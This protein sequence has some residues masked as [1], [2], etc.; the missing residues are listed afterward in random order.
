LGNLPGR[1]GLSVRERVTAGVVTSLARWTPWL[2]SEMCGL[3]PFVPEGGVCIDVGAAA[4]LYT[5]VLSRLAGPDGQVHSI[6]PLPF[7]HLL[8]AGLLNTRQ[9]PNVRHHSLAL[10]AQSG[11]EP[12]SVP[13]GRF[14]LVTGRSFLAR[15]AGG[16]DSNAEFATQITVS[17][18]VRTLDKLC[19][20]EEIGRL[21]FIKVDVEGAE[22]QVLE[23]GKGVIDAHR[24]VLLVEIEAR[25]AARFH[26]S[27]DEVSGWL[28][29]RGY[30]M[31]VWRQGWREADSVE[32]SIRNYLFLPPGRGAAGQ[33]LTAARPGT[34]MP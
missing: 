8:W 19:A 25:H 16:P 29:Q 5:A 1:R 22:L 9:A 11:D 21:D 4:G 7:A 14:G 10:S 3:R 15:Q 12:M 32:P 27:P 24:P 28:L 13:V 18:P 33:T 26:R 31:H 2:E 20:R 17:V 6:E 30:T 34:G 23:G